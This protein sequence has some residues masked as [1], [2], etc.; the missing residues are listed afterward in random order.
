[1]SKIEVTPGLFSQVEFKPSLKSP[2][3]MAGFGLL[4]LIAFGIFGKPGEVIFKWSDKNDAVQLPAW[5]VNSML[6]N[7]VLGIILLAIAALSIA[8]YFTKRKTP[9]YVIIIFGFLG[10][11]SLLGWLATGASQGVMMVFIIGN[12]LLLAIPL[13]LRSEEHTSELQSH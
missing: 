4:V 3:V 10:V 9:M 12:A 2:L 13:I 8:L 5:T 6:L 7:T 1:M 11:F